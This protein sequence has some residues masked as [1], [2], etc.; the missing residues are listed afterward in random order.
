MHLFLA[1]AL[2][3]ARFGAANEEPSM[4]VE[5]FSDRFAFA[6]IFRTKFS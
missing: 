4:A 1:P 2:A 3:F 6:K 5:L